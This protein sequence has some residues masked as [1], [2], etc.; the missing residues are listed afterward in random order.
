M[1]RRGVPWWQLAVAAAA[2]VAAAIAVWV[3]LEADFLAHPGWL[4]AQ[5]A[6]F[7]LGPVF[8]GLYWLR[9][10]PESRFGPVLLTFGAV[11]AVYILQS[12]SNPWLFGF[13]L[14]W[15]NVIYL[16]T[17]VLILTFPTGRLDGLAAKLILTATVIAAVMYSV[18]LLLVPQIGAE[19]SISG[20][21][22]MCPDNALAVTSNLPLAVDLSRLV[23]YS[24]LAIEIATAGLLIWRMVTGTPPQR[25]AFRIGVPIAL[26]FTSFQITNDFLKLVDPDG[27][28][29][30]SVIQWG[31]AGARSLIWYGFLFALIAA[32]LFAGRTLHTLV[33]QSLRRPSLP[34]LEGMV[35]VPL[36]DPDLRLMFLDG[37]SE[38]AADQPLEPGPGREVTIVER[39]DGTPGA[40]I[41]HDAQLADDPE[42]LHA[43]GAVALLAAEN[44]ELDAGWHDALRELRESRARILVAGDTERRKIERNLHDGAQQRLVELRVRVQLVDELIGKDPG[45]RATLLHELGS[46]VDEAIEEVRALARGVYPSLLADLGI[47]RALRAIGRRHP[48]RTT[49]DAEGVGR[50][51]PELES[52]V[53]FCCLEALQ[54]AAKHASTAS[55]VSITLVD[56]GALRFAVRDDGIGFIPGGIWSG[57]G[58]T[59]MLDRLAAVGGELTIESAPGKGTSVLGVIPRPRT[60]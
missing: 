31:M 24:V 41:D 23:R 40:A 34:E 15:E 49:I 58:L 21:R 50:Y 1:Q 60:Q 46:E 53:Y 44:A 19:G 5:K 16:S 27:T 42:L 6:D 32:Q 38:T 37:K 28:A 4:A 13:S 43:A 54:N 26:V 35:R 45:R 33:R 48:I 29:L 11:A 17:L 8:V 57:Q 59:N 3:T 25:R 30:D 39:G 22:A 20:C 18:T 36:G 55:T 9:Q 7:I 47:V 12:S 56:D 52:A 2:L 14:Q 51:P 10:R